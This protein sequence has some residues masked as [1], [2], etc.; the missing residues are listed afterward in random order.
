M[1]LMPSMTKAVRRSRSMPTWLTSQPSFD[2]VSVR[3]RPM[4]SSPTFD[5]M[6]DFKP[7]RAVPKAMFA[8]EPPRY[9]AKLVASSRGLPI[10][11]AYRSTARRPRQITSSARPWANCVELFMAILKS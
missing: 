2:R 8:D 1:S 10:C 7:R 4:W 9:L 5:S 6:A 11:C 3:K